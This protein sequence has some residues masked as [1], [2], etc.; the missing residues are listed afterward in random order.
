MERRR[1]CAQTLPGCQALVVRSATK[2]TRTA[3]W[4][5]A[6]QLALIGRAGIGVD[7]IDLGAA[8]QRGIVV[9][10]TPEA[11]AV[12]T[13]EHAISLLLSI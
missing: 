4:R 9:M 13:G 5:L 2:V 12:T 1:R 11:G 6:D 10:N 8:T 3:A 7:N